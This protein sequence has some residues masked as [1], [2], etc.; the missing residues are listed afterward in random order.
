MANQILV[1]FGI[2]DLRLLTNN[3]DKL[4]ALKGFGNRRIVREELSIPANGN[5]HH[6]L[7]TKCR[8]FGHQIEIP[9]AIESMS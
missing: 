9:P 5:N 7:L 1:H 3:P 4:D 8:K 6:Y 2:D